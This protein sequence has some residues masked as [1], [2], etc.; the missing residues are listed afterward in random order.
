[1]KKVIK[2]V[3]KP[4]FRLVCFIIITTLL[5]VSAINLYIIFSVN[6]FISVPDTITVE[7]ADCIL[8]LGAGVRPDGTPSLMLQ[9]RL[10]TAVEL[11]NAGLCDKILMSG[12][13]GTKYYNEVQAMENYAVEKGIPSEQIFLDHAGFSTYE[14]VYRAKEIFKADKV[15]IVTQKYHLYRAVYD[16]RRLGLEAYGVQSEGDN[17]AGQSY[18]SLREAFARVKDF[19]ITIYKPMPTYLGES[20][21]V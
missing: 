7:D 12:D 21:P 4:L 11:Y 18:R 3:A 8:V 14:S 16:A 6:N 10:N 13:H 20:I 15:V 9:D 5:T 1:M 17:Y 19:F 2:K